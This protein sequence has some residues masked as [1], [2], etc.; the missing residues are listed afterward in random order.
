[1]AHLNA[2]PVSAD[3]KLNNLLH[4][5]KQ[6]HAALVAI[7]SAGMLELGRDGR[8]ESVAMHENGELLIDGAQALLRM[9][10]DDAEV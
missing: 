10:I 1:M 2:V 4:Q 7:N 3:M 8:P 9:A 6:A 5:A